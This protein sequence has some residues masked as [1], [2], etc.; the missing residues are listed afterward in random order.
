[1]PNP[2]TYIETAIYAIQKQGEKDD[3]SDGYINTREPW[4][5]SSLEE[6]ETAFKNAHGHRRLV[7]VATRA[8]EP[9]LTEIKR[10]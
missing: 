8:N 1:M 10:V 6:A 4:A 9:D 2:Y 7:K 5:F 3:F